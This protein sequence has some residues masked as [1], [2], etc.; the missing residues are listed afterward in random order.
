VCEGVADLAAL[1]DGTLLIAANSPKNMPADGGGAL[2]KL[3]EPHAPAELL[4]R[5]D[6]LKPEG[7]AL[8]PTGKDVVVVFDT[9]GKKPL[10]IRLSLSP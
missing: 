4:K 8:T 7:V 5:F 6:G 3:K 9:D 10:W 2:W 1:P